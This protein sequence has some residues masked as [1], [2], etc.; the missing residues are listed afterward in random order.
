MNL[1]LLAVPFKEDELEWRVAKCGKDNKGFWAD[2]LAYVQAR[3]I[4]DRLD[5]VCG[6]ENWRASYRFEGGGVICKLEIRVHQMIGNF[7]GTHEWLSKEDGSEL[8]EFEAFK[9]G[10]SGA[11]KR[12]AVPWGIGR[13]LYSLEVGSAVI[14]DSTHKLRRWGKTKNN[15]EFFWVPP[16][17][18]SWALPPSDQDKAALPTVKPDQP[19]SNDGVQFDEYALPSFAGI[20]AMKPMSHCETIKL[21]G[22]RDA[23]KIKYLGKNIPPKTLEMLNRVE[24]EIIKRVNKEF[25]DAENG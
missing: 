12:A 21:E 5:E 9:G 24:E 18:P 11:L 23:T 6:P 3:A 17:L 25:K 19:K 8:T 13:Y 22:L 7:T 16:R 2:V 15:E 14:V 4:M 1:K 10:I 20:L